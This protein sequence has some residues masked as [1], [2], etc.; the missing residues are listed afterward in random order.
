M[1][2]PTLQPNETL[3]IMSCGH[4][5]AAVRNMDNIDRVF[6]ENSDTEITV[7]SIDW[8]YFNHSDEWE[9]EVMEEPVVDSL[10]GDQTTKFVY[11]AKVAW[12]Y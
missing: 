1:E 4:I 12:T 2:R 3:V 9:L 7:T 10:F 8:T 6:I 11:T 5:I